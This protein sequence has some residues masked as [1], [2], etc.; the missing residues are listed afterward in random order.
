MELVNGLLPTK[1][2]DEVAQG[3]QSGWNFIC[4]FVTPC[5]THQKSIIHRDLKP[6][7]ILVTL[8]DGQPDP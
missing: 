8:I 3:L 5:S 2:C 1:F 6:A 7:N 4:R